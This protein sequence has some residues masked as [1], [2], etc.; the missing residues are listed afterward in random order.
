MYIICTGLK[1][2]IYCLHILLRFSTYR[3]LR[4]RTP[5]LIPLHQSIPYLIKLQLSSHP[6][7]K[8]DSSP[9]PDCHIPRL[10]FLS[11][12]L[13]LFFL[14]DCCLCTLSPKRKMIRG[15]MILSVSFV[16]V[17]YTQ[18]FWRPTSGLLN[19]PRALVRL[20]HLFPLHHS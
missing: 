6:R 2:L 4:C 15:M 12:F 7:R 9:P 13:D 8:A 3:F 5:S 18:T 14:C 16:F 11:P 20:P 10:L 19:F 17:Y 1:F